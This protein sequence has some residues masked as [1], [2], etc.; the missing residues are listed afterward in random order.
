MTA[1]DAP[2]WLEGRPER[3]GPRPIGGKERAPAGPR[4]TVGDTDTDGR[5]SFIGR[6]L[7][8][9]GG[10]IVALVV[11][12]TLSDFVGRLTYPILIP[13]FPYLYGTTLL[14]TVVFGIVGLFTVLRSRDTGW[15]IFLL[16]VG[17]WIFAFALFDSI[18]QWF[19][20]QTGKG[21]SGG[22]VN[23]LAIT[24]YMAALG[25]AILIHMNQV[26]R[27]LKAFFAERGVDTEELA[28]VEGRVRLTAHK[29][30]W[31]LV[32]V[33]AASSVVLLVGELVLGRA[34]LGS[35]GLGIMAGLAVILVLATL[36][37][38]ALSE[39]PEG[40]V[41]NEETTRRT[42]TEDDPKR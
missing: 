17:L 5:S 21:S 38:R 7:L 13:E 29:V 6:Q 8:L 3:S 23:V 24:A 11:G 2:R 20:F 34:T 39:E 40:V 4:D 15:P 32:G 10:V 33:I 37:F 12:Q 9:I 1:R 27:R 36:V 41:E 25:F 28:G 22:R 31:P 16:F 19:V 30:V 42:P 18:L 35:G 26:A 14:A